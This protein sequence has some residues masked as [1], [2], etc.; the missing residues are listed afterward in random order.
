MTTT[1]I[2]NGRKAFTEFDHQRSYYN[3]QPWVATWDGY[4]GA[5]IDNETPSDDPIGYGFTEQEA[6][7]DLLESTR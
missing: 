4:D 5:P 1:H 6:L 2:I 7:D 3:C